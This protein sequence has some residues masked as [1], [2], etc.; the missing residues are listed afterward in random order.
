MKRI[1]I[2]VFVLLVA[3]SCGNDTDSEKARQEIMDTE[4]AFQ[5]MASEKGLADAF[6]F[7]ADENAVINRGNDSLIFGKENI[8]S[9]YAQNSNPAAK[10]SW[11]PDFVEVSDCGTLGYTYGKYFYTVKDSLGTDHTQTGIFHT[12]W[13]KR[14]EEWRYVWD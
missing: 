11:I 10:L 3:V 7:F 9:Y 8:K 13:R 12:V 14:D 4:K 5:E 2:P 6:Y 1:L